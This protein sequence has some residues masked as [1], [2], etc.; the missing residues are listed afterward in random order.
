MRTLAAHVVEAWMR[1]DLRRSFQRIEWHGPWP[2]ALP[3]A[4][5]LIVCANHHHFYDGHLLWYLLTDTLGRPSMVWMQEWNR[6]PLF[7]PVGALPFP[8]DD[9]QT[10]ATT[11]R[12]TARQFQAHP[13]AALFYFPSGTLQSPNVGIGPYAVERFVRLHRLYP[14]ALFW[15]VALHVTWD[16]APHPVA[17]FRAG[18]CLDL[19]RQAPGAIETHLRCQWRRLRETT[20]APTHLLMRGRTSPADRWSFAWTLPLFKRLLPP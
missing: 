9:P 2:P 8:P 10:R 13:G 5:P 20:A 11:V 6:F 4:R 14:D 3:E 15:P 1:W 7:A 17:Q 12:R 19:E 18:P 16:G